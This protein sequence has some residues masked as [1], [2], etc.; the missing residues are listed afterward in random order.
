MANSAMRQIDSPRLITSPDKSV[1]GPTGNKMVLIIARAIMRVNVVT[2][3]RVRI[4]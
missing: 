3:L 4:G 1:I 2:T